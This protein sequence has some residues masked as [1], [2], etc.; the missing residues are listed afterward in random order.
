MNRGSSVEE[1]VKNIQMPAGMK[2]NPYLRENYGNNEFNV[3]GL[4]SKYSGWF[5]QN[6]TH[7]RPVQ[8]KEKAESFIESMGGADAVLRNARQLHQAKKLKLALEYLDLLID[9]NL[10][11]REARLEKAIIL[12][13]LAKTDSDNPLIINMYEKLASMEREKAQESQK[14]SKPDG[15][16]QILSAPQGDSPDPLPD[17][18]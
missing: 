16:P 1:A 2:S 5:D 15:N 17:S 18:K 11:E 3:R 6:G 14:L 13:A 10:L 4:Y 9:A 8:T 12:D 7:I